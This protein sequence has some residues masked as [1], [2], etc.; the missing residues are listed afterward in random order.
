MR[1][2][3]RFRG[4]VKAPG[5]AWD[6]L[7]RGKYGFVYDQMPITATQ[8][9]IQKRINLAKAGINL[10]KRTLTPWGMPLHM[11]FELTNYCNL[12]CPVCPTGIGA[13]ERKKQNM[14]ADLFR[15]IVDQVGPYLLTGSLWAWGEPLLH[16]EI[17]HILETASGYPFV[18][19][20]STNGQNLNSERVIQ[21]LI[22]YPPTFLIVALDGLTDETNRRFRKGA[23][24]SPALEGVRRIAEL[25][26]KLNRTL[27]VL[28]MRFM[29]MKHNE[30]QVPELERFAR[31]HCFDFLTVRTL[32]IIDTDTPDDIHRHF[33]PNSREMRAY[34]YKDG[35]RIER[36]DY[37]CLEP[38]WFPTVFADGTLVACEQDYN[39][40][41]SFGKLSDAVSFR[42][43]WYSDVSRKIRRRIRDCPQE[44][45]FC[46]HCPYRD[47]DTTDFSIK[48]YFLNE[49]I[50][51]SKLL[52][53][54]SSGR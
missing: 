54:A 44:V 3:E 50:D 7:I 37:Y 20:L 17:D 51:Y 26:K 24:L 30:F 18:K 31:E 11:Q 2:N 9:S 53:S 36:D 34:A 43:L 33:I 45:S 27:P 13:V 29:V 48:A 46:N 47:R 15:K 6:T 5:L 23:R 42:D 22:H 10:A 1:A 35:K 16:P 14:T 19:F 32:S 52:Q 40:S 49:S 39:A 38:F 28:H 12:K 25:K 4:L 21:A 41:L 8:M